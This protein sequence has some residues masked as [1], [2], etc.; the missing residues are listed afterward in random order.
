MGVVFGGHF[1]DTHSH[2]VVLGVGEVS[3][4]VLARVDVAED[5]GRVQGVEDGCHSGPGGV[6]AVHVGRRLVQQELD[7]LVGLFVNGSV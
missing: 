5:A 4:L 1:L 7:H 6:L 2:E 3:A